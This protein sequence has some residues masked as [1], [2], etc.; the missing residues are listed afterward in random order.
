[1]KLTELQKQEI[2]RRYVAGESPKALG[3]VF[4]VSRQTIHNIVN[5]AGVWRMRV[6]K[7]KEG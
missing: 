7:Y 2:V 5:R 3:G 6:I 1:M 4:G